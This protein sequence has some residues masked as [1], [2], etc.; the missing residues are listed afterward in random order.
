MSSLSTYTT[1]PQVY[2]RSRTLNY[3]H[4][5]KVGAFVKLYRAMAAQLGSE[6]KVSELIG[7]SRHTMSDAATLNKLT[8][9]AA[10]QVLQGYRAWKA[11][12]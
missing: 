2:S 12:Q 5:S 9:R 8:D 11:K 3:I 4:P 6:N 10:R 1:A 7:V